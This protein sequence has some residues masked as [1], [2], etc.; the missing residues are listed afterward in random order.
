MKADSKKTKHSEYKKTIAA[1]LVVIMVS[2]V[3]F[4]NLFTHVVTIVRYYGDAMEPALSDGQLLAVLQTDNVK[5]GD[6]VAFYYN[7][8]VIIRRVICEGDNQIIIEKNGKV[9]V[10]GEELTES[11]VSDL[12]IGQ[13]NIDFPYYVIPGH[14]FVMGDNRTVSMDSRLK[15]IGTV[16]QERIIGKVIFAI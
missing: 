16:P 15:E 4:M 9:A 6:M 2:A 8:Q 3:L 13:C 14:F 1:L 12:S 7:N 10:N 11:Y 5:Q